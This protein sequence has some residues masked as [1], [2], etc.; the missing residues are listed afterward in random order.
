MS[1]EEVVKPRDR[2]FHFEILGFLDGTMINE[3]HEAILARQRNFKE[4]P[5]EFSFFY[6][7]MNIGERKRTFVSINPNEEE[8]WRG[9]VNEIT[10]NDDNVPVAPDGYPVVQ[11]N[12]VRLA[13]VS[14]EAEEHQAL[15]S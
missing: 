15:T 11:M 2:K 6:V 10:L 1:D 5:Y 9:Q 13:Y 4:E 7:L 14:V 3:I 8:R 12:N